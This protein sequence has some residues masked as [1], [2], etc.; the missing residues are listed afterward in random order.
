MLAEEQQQTEPVTGV[1]TEEAILRAHLLDRMVEIRSQDPDGGVYRRVA[2]V[3]DVRLV[4]RVLTF[5]S[6]RGGRILRCDLSD[7]ELLSGPPET[8][9]LLRAAGA[10]EPVRLAVTPSSPVRRSVDRAAKRP[11]VRGRRRARGQDD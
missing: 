9:L 2:W 11:P 10:E 1:D 7:I 6:P 4:G 5:F 8:V 3:A